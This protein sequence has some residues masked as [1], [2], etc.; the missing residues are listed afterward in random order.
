MKYI[1]SLVMMLVLCSSCSWAPERAFTKA[2]LYKT[3][4]YTYF[5]IE[6][7][8][9]SV[10]SAINKEGEVVLN[11]KY[12]SRDVWIKILGKL[13]GLTVQIIEK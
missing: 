11:A 10:L 13:E 3:G 6:D 7:S 1:L 4:I 12:R 8:P 5:A 2:E 9:E